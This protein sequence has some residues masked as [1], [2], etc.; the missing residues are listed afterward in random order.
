MLSNSNVSIMDPNP[1]MPC[2]AK[3]YGC[4]NIYSLPQHGEVTNKFFCSTCW[5]P[6]KR[7]SNWDPPVKIHGIDPYKMQVVCVNVNC[8]AILNIDTTDLFKI[9]T[10][11]NC[12]LCRL[13]LSRYVFAVDPSL[14]SQP[15]EEF[16]K[17]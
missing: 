6:H 15:A 14:M 7:I 9:S 2:R 16:P 11:F 4:Q 1:L 17:V 8:M 5:D 3:C 12:P 13:P 10:C